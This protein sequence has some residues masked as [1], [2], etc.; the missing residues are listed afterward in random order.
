MESALERAESLPLDQAAIVLAGQETVPTPGDHRRPSR[1]ASTWPDDWA[2]QEAAYGGCMWAGVSDAA[3][4][5]AT[6]LVDALGDHT[7]RPW[8]LYLRAHAAYVSHLDDGRDDR[9][10][11]AV[12]DLEGGWARCG[13]DH[14][15][16]TCASCDAAAPRASADSRGGRRGW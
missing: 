3:L 15:V 16:W 7:L 11:A 8:W 4:A 5:A 14:V 1:T 6:R 2:D 12:A 10:E 13:S 9:L